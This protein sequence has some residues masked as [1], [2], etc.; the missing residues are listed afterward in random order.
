MMYVSPCVKPIELRVSLT[1][2]TFAL[3]SPSTMI[4]SELGTKLDRISEN[5]QSGLRGKYILTSVCLL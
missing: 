3:K 5:S 4:L 1:V 2:S